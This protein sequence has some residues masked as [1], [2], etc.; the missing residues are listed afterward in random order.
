MASTC[1]SS[2]TSQRMA[3]TLW[4]LAVRS[5]TAAHT[6]LS[7]KSASATDAPDSAKAFAVARPS[8][9]PAPVTSATFPSNEMFMEIAPVDASIGLAPLALRA[10]RFCPRV[11]VALYSD[12][13]GGFLDVLEIVG[14]KLARSR[15]D[16]LLEPVELGSAG[17]RDDPR[18]LCQQPG[19]CD[20]RRSRALLLADLFQQIDH[21]PVCL[22]SLGRKARQAGAIVVAAEGGGLVDLAG[23]EAPA[24]GTKGNEAD[25][26]LRANRQHLRLGLTPPEGIFAL[27]RGDRLNRVRAADGRGAS[28]AEAEMLNL[29]LCDQILHRAGDVLDR[30]IG[31]D[32]V[33]V[34]QV[35]RLN[36][37]PLQRAFGRLPDAFGATVKPAGSAVTEVVAEL[38]GDD[39]V[40]SEW[41]QRLAHEFLVGERT[42]DRGGVEESDTALER[43]PD[44]RDHLF[45]VGAGAGVVFQPHTAKADGRNREAAVAKL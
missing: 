13:R 28:F 10:L 42:I 41:L 30:D 33:L 9:D 32:P 19:E 40:L 25:P 23:E 2:A 18:L 21:W 38:G 24:Q 39:D 3:S 34:E 11:A 20:L 29:A 27:D 22:A 7:F 16:V 8:P 14:R 1:A 12:L 4:P 5:S 44:E 43:R 35:D 45:A 31:I 36:P 6:A 37:Q 17:N 26:Q 15:A